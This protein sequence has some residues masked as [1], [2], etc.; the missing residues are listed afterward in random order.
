MKIIPSEKFDKRQVFSFK[1][2]DIRVVREILNDVRRDGDRAIIKYSEKFDNVR[3]DSDL[4]RVEQSRIK[5]AKDSIDSKLEKAINFSKKNIERFYKAQLRG[6]KDFEVETTDGVF[7]YGRVIPINRIGIYVPAGNFPLLSTLIMCAVPARVS[8]VKEIAVFSPPRSNGDVHITILQ[9]ASLL[10]I[11]EVYRIGGV[12]A[13]AAMAY[14]TESIKQ[15]DKI[16]GPGNKFIA[17]AKKEVFGQ[18][19]IDMVAGPSEVMIIADESADP[20]YIAADMI[21]QAE[22]DINASSI[23]LTTSKR[24]ADRVIARIRCQFVENPNRKIIEKSLERNGYIVVCK[25]IDECIHIA[26]D[27]SP[28]HLEVILQDTKNVIPKLKNYGSLFIG[29]YSAE[30]FGDYTAGINHTLPTS[31]AARYRGGLSVLD[32][33]KIVTQLKVDK[34]GYNSLKESTLI[35]AEKEGLIGHYYAAKIREK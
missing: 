35:L 16:V 9:T 5:D 17:I 27:I 4:F 18:V 20:S 21:A 26:N 11:K 28:E 19:G 29:K 31:K 10:G 24:V 7:C 33:V 25:N 1:E 6:L 13:I 30:V 14:G 8:G 3:L 15:V 23:L 32:F 2:E 34:K 12:Q 22:H